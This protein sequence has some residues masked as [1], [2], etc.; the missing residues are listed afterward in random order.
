MAKKNIYSEVIRQAN[1]ADFLNIS[2]NGDS[3]TIVTS[4]WVFV[5]SA[6]QYVL[7]IANEIKG[8][9][10]VKD[11]ECY[12]RQGKNPVGQGEPFKNVTE[13]F[14][15]AE[16]GESATVTKFD[17]ELPEVMTRVIRLENGEYSTINKD[18]FKMVESLMG[19]ECIVR[20]VNKNSPIAFKL[21]ESEKMLIC[22]IG[23]T[24]IDKDIESTFYPTVELSAKNPIKAEP[25]PKKAKAEPKKATAKKQ[26]KKAEPKKAKAEP[27]AEKKP[28]NEEVAKAYW[29]RNEEH[30]GLEVVFPSTPKA[31]IRTAL[32]TNG[33]RWHNA[34]KMWFAKE[35]KD[36]LALVES[37]VK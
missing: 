13:M 35:T 36:R 24:N 14:G 17:Y 12:I 8:F 25:K 31:E 34:K 37:L 29:R 4:H 21:R 32:K 1:K 16:S 15:T 33:F 30:K 11:G 9:P 28:T 5:T 23:R 27:V 6:E 7:A 2:L 26:S 20:A 19:S 22:P 3:A 18:Y 10:V